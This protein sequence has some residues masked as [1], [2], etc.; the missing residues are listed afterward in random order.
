V[1]A[2][3]KIFAVLCTKYD[4]GKK[5][6]Y[7]GKIDRTMAFRTSSM[8]RRRIILK[9]FWSESPLFVRK[10]MV[11]SMVIGTKWTKNIMKSMGIGTNSMAFSTIKISCAKRHG[12]CAKKHGGFKKKSLD[13][14]A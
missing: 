8:P 14:H 12:V 1:L 7:N 11:R 10:G 3:W 5:N 4:N 2:T 6:L 13:I 9:K